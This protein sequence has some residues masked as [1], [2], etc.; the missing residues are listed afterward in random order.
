MASFSRDSLT[1]PGFHSDD[2]VSRRHWSRKLHLLSALHPRQE[3]KRAQAAGVF[4]F[5]TACFVDRGNVYLR[6]LPCVPDL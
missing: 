2:R 5:D 1:P 3:N 4:A 6:R